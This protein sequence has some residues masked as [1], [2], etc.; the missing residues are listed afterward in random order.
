MAR[1][2]DHTQEQ[3]KELILNSA[4]G[5]IIKE[6][7]AAL[8]ARRIAQQTGYTV[9]SIYMVFNSMQDLLYHIRARSLADLTGQLI[10][11][12]TAV[13]AEQSINT[14]ASLYL[15]FAKQHFNQWILLFEAVKHVQEDLPEW[16][17]E[18]INDLFLAFEQ[19]IKLLRPDI[20]AKEISLTARSLWCGIHGICVVCLNGNLGDTG[21]KET[22]N[23]INILV[24]NFIRGYLSTDQ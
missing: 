20:P 22:E 23:A 15:N 16:Y 13:P 17:L 12:S 5:I 18:K 4:E 24:N 14:L 11:V 3:I 9:G 8:T 2:N 1:R 7:L 6:G 10:T 21:I 19:P